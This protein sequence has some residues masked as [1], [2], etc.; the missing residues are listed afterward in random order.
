MVAMVRNDNSDWSKTG[1]SSGEID[2]ESWNNSA[3]SPWMASNS[4]DDHGMSE[5]ENRKVI[6]RV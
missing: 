6:F 5:Y 4:L 2:E 3:L 1:I